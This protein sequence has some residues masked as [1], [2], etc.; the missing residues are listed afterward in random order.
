MIA[1]V[2]NDILFKAA[3]F[4]LFEE[5]IPRRYQ[6]R[7]TSVGILGAARYVIPKKIEKNVQAKIATAAKAAFQAFVDTAEIIEPTEEEQLMAA[8]FELAAQRAAVALDSGE[9]QLCAVLIVRALRLLLTGDKRAICA[10][11]QLLDTDTRLTALAGKVT[12]LEQLVLEPLSA[13]NYSKFRTAVCWETAV[14]KTLSICFSCKAEEATF[15]STAAGLKSYINDL[16]SQAD[17]I[18]AP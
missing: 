13:E 10:L 2:D 7:E 12:C 11:E 17:R 1:L 3:C 14:D 16:R 15:E 5:L 6:L 8:D 9:S 4:G 18:L